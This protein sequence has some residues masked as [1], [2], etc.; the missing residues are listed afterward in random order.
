M[1]SVIT[2]AEARKITGGRTPLVPIE[3]ERAIKDLVACTTLDEAKYWDTKSDA[4]AAW[5]KIYRNDEVGIEARR[6]K[7][8]AYR[9][10]GEIAHELRPG[11][12]G[13][14]KGHVGALKGAP[15]LLI[16][17]GLKLE[18]ANAASYLGKLPEREFKAIVDLPRP[19]TPASTRPS[20]NNGQTSAW[21]TLAGSAGGNTFT[22]FLAYCRRHDPKNLASGLS[23]DEVKRVKPMAI[24]I[25]D[26]IDEFERSLKRA[27][28]N[29][30][31]GLTK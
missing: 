21:I 15:S 22:G 20:H 24:E 26:W 19:P 8:H 14:V 27:S 23:Q 10:M 16:E 6:L 9:R 30:S 5:A 12:R 11:S 29:S 18:Q 4:L 1:Q 7:L 31:E 2:A 28:S 17:K 25:A 3:Y 13:A